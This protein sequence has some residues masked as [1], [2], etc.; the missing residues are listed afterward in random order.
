MVEMKKQIG[1][2]DLTPTW[3]EILPMLLLAIEDGNATG[4]QVAREELARMAGIAD[5]YVSYIREV[6]NRS[7]Q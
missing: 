7:G 5:K 3:S 4:K 2:V 1:T 6:A